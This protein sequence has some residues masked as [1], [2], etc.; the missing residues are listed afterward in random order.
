MSKEIPKKL[1]SDNEEQII[2]VLTKEIEKH[3]KDSKG[4][5]SLHYI[6]TL[7]NMIYDF[8]VQDMSK[9]DV[10][11]TFFIMFAY[12]LYKTEFFKYFEEAYTNKKEIIDKKEMN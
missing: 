12:A 4:K 6:G 11:I 7:S 5:N 10:I 8:I 2:K 1:F 9:K 3:I